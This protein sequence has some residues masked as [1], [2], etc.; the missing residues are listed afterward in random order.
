MSVDV[1]VNIYLR[2]IDG[3]AAET[4]GSSAAALDNLS[5]SSEGMQ[6]MFQ[7]R[8]QHIG[9]MIF[10]GDALH[11][12]GL[13]RETRM[14][15]STL[16]MAL[17]EGAAAAGISSGGLMLIAVALIAVI[18]LVMK[19]T[20]HH[21]DLVAQLDKTRDS[22]GKEYKEAFDTANAVA[23]YGKQVGLLTEGQ[24]KLHMAEYNLS[25]MR[26]AELITTT[27]QEI[28][29]IKASIA[30]NVAHAQTM[31]T[32]HF[33]VALAGAAFDV[34][35]KQL[36]IVGVVVAHLIPGFTAFRERIHD[37]VALLPHVAVGTKL[38]ASEMEE[39]TKKQIPLI[40]K[41]YEL[42]DSFKHL[43]KSSKDADTEMTDANKKAVDEMTKKMNEWIKKQQQD[44]LFVSEEWK[45]AWKNVTSDFLNQGSQAFAQM[46]VE[47]N[48][49]VDSM[50]TA[51]K[52][53]A[54][55][56]ISAVTQMIA[57]WAI[58]TALTGMGGSSAVV[59]G[60]LGITK[61]Q[62]GFSGMV[63]KPTLFMAGEAGPEYVHVTPGGEGG[64]GGGTSNV[65]VGDIHVNVS[66]GQLDSA[67]ARQVLE[68]LADELRRGTVDAV[69][70]ATASAGLATRFPKYAV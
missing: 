9:L 8:F 11:A 27:H 56:F 16:N 38:T 3:T 51:F 54:E 46:V 31:H 21:K 57:K 1:D 20:S 69:R 64:G 26:K 19:A 6:S 39:L 70:F 30:A 43:G 10:A 58:F 41:M 7:R 23:A 32:V 36:T 35:A 63:D 4:I 37:L 50:K 12:A 61:A 65:I 18:G 22:L 28:E 17:I 45:K 47:G 5:A 59:G 13:G 48:N 68:S 44:L 66:V 53:L 29:A 14:V 67:G 15:I 2:A 25:E 42:M 62:S 60:F 24:Q 33:Y 49:F 34:L 55:S 40:A 52:N